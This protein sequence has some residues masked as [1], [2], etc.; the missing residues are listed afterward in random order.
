MKVSRRYCDY[1]YDNNCIIFFDAD[2]EENKD[3][4]ETKFNWISSGDDKD[5]KYHAEILNQQK[6]KQEEAGFKN[7]QLNMS[8]KPLR[9]YLE[10]KYQ[11]NKAIIKH[12]KHQ[13]LLKSQMLTHK[14]QIESMAAYQNMSPISY[15]NT[16]P[17]RH[18]PHGQGQHQPQYQ[19][20]H[21]NNNDTMQY[22]NNHNNNNNMMNPHYAAMNMPMM[23]NIHHSPKQYI[24][25]NNNFNGNYRANIMRMRPNNIMY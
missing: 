25:P 7:K 4:F 24:D 1:D 14:Q 18:H 9:Q 23:Q 12:Q 16:S 5:K 15:Q 22:M 2:D 11:E 19:W 13:K 6:A 21:A 3:Q 20:I 10:I 17:I 8:K